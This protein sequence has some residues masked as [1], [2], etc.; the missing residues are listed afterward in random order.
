MKNKTKVILCTV[1]VAGV[2]GVSGILAY[3]TDT[4]SA[5]NKFTVGKVDINLLEPSWSTTDANS[6]GTPDSAENMTANQ[7]I[8]KDPEVQNVGKNPAYVYLKVTVPSA[9]V[10]TANS[11]GTLANSGAAKDTQLFTYTIDSDNWAEIESKRT[12]NTNSTTGAVESYTYVYYYKQALATSATTKPLFSTVTFAN[13]IEGQLEDS[14]SAQQ[15]DI[16][17]YAIQSDNLPNSTT[18][19]SAYDIY[20]NQKK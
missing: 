6:N 11:D 2:V 18:I 10:I 12:T 1:A 8:S 20:L 15:I 14:A 5:S 16:Q 9:K 4:A 17:A 7:T 13:V 3:L 19:A